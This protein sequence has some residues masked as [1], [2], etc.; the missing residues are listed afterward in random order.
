[1]MRYYNNLVYSP[2]GAN[3]RCFQQFPL[4]YSSCVF[5]LEIWK[6]FDI[7]FSFA[8]LQIEDLPVA[9]YGAASVNIPGRGWYLF[10]GNNEPNAQVLTGVGQQWAAGPPVNTI[11]I[12]FRCAVQ[13]TTVLFRFFCVKG[14]LLPSLFL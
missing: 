1:M 11:N 12:F 7:L 3:F 5:L 10:G 13:V 9:T 8:T 2:N 4:T 6:S 14:T